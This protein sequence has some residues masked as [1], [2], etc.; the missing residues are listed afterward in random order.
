MLLCRAP[1]WCLAEAATS[2]QDLAETE[3]CCCGNAKR[4]PL[5]LREPCWNKGWSQCPLATV[6]AEAPTLSIGTEAEISL[7]GSPRLDMSCIEGGRYL[8][9]RERWILELEDYLDTAD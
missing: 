4:L 1:L 6:I 7:E 8:H 5:N 3:E 2:P 9:R